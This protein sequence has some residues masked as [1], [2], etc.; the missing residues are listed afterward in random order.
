MGGEG[1]GEFAWMIVTKG[2]KADS[3]LLSVC[4][5]AFDL[6]K[7]AETDEGTVQGN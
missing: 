4:N 3:G 1:R 5:I 2:A 6:L 7:V